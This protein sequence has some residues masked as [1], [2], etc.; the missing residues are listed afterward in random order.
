MLWFFVFHLF[1]SVVLIILFDACIAPAQPT[2]GFMGCL[3]LISTL[4]LPWVAELLGC[5]KIQARPEW[6]VQMV[7]PLPPIS[8]TPST[9]H[10]GPL[11]FTWS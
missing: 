9:L 4:R 11:F 8:S 10:H 3:I 5:P 2:E 1:P 6:Q 7:V